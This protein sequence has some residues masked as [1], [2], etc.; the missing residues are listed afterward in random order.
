[1][2]LAIN[3]AKILA[4]DASQLLA[5]LSRLLEFNFGE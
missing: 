3:G 1:M 5:E 4:N 2:E